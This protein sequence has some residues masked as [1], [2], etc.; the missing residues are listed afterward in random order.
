MEIILKFIAATV[1]LQLSSSKL[2]STVYFICTK[3]SAYQ[4]A[5]LSIVIYHV[6]RYMLVVSTFT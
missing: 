4:L 3:S 1:R 6:H 2:Y 5:I